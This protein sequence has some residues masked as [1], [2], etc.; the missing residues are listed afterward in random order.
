[1]VI[2]SVWVKPF[3]KSNRC[4]V[5]QNSLVLQ[6]TCK[7]TQ[8]IIGL[9]CS[10]SPLAALR[11]LYILQYVL[12]VLG[13]HLSR[14]FTYSIIRLVAILRERF[15]LIT[16]NL[17]II[18]FLHSKKWNIWSQ[19][20]CR[21]WVPNVMTSSSWASTFSMVIMMLKLKQR[22]YQRETN[23]PVDQFWQKTSFEIDLYLINLNLF[24]SW[25]FEGCSEQRSWTWNHCRIGTRYK[26]KSY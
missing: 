1:M 17:S 9:P 15:Q 6:E 10:R 5:C 8:I 22:M 13:L 12:R 16:L 4:H 7:I 21:F 14:L 3:P 19:S 25:M 26:T 11:V 23:V 20:F 18:S 24:C 2:I